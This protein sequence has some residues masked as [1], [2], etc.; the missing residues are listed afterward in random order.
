GQRPHAVDRGAFRVGLAEDIIENLERPGSAVPGCEH[1]G[2]EAGKVEAALP[3]KAPVVTAPRER[4]HI[5]WRR[6]G[7]LQE[8]DLLS[9]DVAD[10]AGIMAEGQDVEAVQAD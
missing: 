6:I 1:L 3:G 4:V 8:E 2:G 5:Q 9:G 7:E 10:R